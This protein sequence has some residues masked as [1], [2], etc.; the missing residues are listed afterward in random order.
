MNASIVEALQSLP[1]LLATPVG[2]DILAKS[3]VIVLIASAASFLL[4]QS[5][6]ATRYA[7]WGTTFAMLMVL[8]LFSLVLPSWTLVGEGDSWVAPET[9]R[10]AS[11]ISISDTPAMLAAHSVTDG[12]VSEPSSPWTSGFAIVRVLPSLALLLWLGGALLM[13]ARLGVHVL[14]VNRVTSAPVAKRN[15]SIERIARPVIAALGIRGDVRVLVSPEAS[16]PFCWGIRKPAIVLPAIAE[17]WPA[18]QTRSVLMHELAHIA[19]RDYPVHLL[20]EIARACYWINPLVWLA[21]RRCA[22]ERERACD[23]VAL[24]HGTASDAYAHHLLEMARLAVQGYAT[25]GATSMAGEPGLVERIR[26]VMNHRIDRSPMRTRGVLLTICVALLAV[27]P[28]ATC[29]MWEQQWNVPTTKEAIA[30]LLGDD[31]PRIRQRAAWWLGEHEDRAAVSP[32]LRVLGDESPGVCVVAAWALG[33]IKDET[34]IEALVQSLGHDDPLVREMVVLALG[35]IEHP[36]AVNPLV[37]MFEQDSRTREAVIWALG[38]I[39]R[40]GDPKAEEARATA[41]AM[42]NRDPWRNGEVWAGKLDPGASEF[43]QD[44]SGILGQLR[45]GTPEERRRAAWNLGFLGILDSWES[46]RE[47]RRAVDGLIAALGDP[48]PEV[49]AMAAWSLDEINPSRSWRSRGEFPMN[50]TETEYQLNNLGYYLAQVGDLDRA[51]EI[52]RANVDLF[53]QSANTYDSLGEAY[54]RSGHLDLAVH[55]YQES[56]KRDPQNENAVR[57]L[58]HLTKAV[59]GSKPM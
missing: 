35:E 49:R 9:S 13:L 41:F 3:T 26:C 28:L 18:D 1:A 44:V 6:A 58:E 7:I 45:G 56:L 47:V 57:M 17:E 40:R 33:E 21:A 30:D 42:W 31:D 4:R 34:S 51:L 36:T 55:Y 46:A 52:F 48:A 25:S 2:L 24:R 59:G 54:M 22:M 5:S 32:L 53:P 15:R 8:P 16:I 12:D 27:A 10:P 50:M 39:A 38:E 37:E 14:R 11:T 43:S 23:D 20:V 19:R 29:E